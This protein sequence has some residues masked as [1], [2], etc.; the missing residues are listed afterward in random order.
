M[1]GV[2]VSIRS[3][4][5]EDAQRIHELHTA[6]VR[7]LCA[8]HYTPEIVE[9]WLA[10]RTAQGYL[11]GIGAGA[12]I[13]AELA[14]NVVGF[15]EGVPG[16][17]VAVFVDP[18]FVN[19]GIGSI[20]LEHTLRLTQEHQGTV[21]LESTL[22]AVGFYERFGFSQVERS[23]VRRNQVEIPIVVMQRHGES[24]RFLT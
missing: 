18:V 22:N 19:R 15:G 16:E 12:T 14:S 21:R 7:V 20:L 23:L 6:A 8:P 3:A 24:H 11:R 17:V 4:T 5:T 10:N 9:G 2:Q 1:V 13:V